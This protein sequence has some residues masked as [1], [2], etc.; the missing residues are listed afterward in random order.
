MTRRVAR[1][2]LAGREAGGEERMLNKWMKHRSASIPKG[3]AL[4][5]TALFFS[6]L[7]VLLFGVV[8]VGVAVNTYL[9]V[10]NA[11]R[12]GG[13]YAVSDPDHSNAQTA[14]VV[15]TAMSNLAYL[16]AT[17]ATIVITR[18]KTHTTG[19]ATTIT[20]YVVYYEPTLGTQPSRFTPD[21]VGA[22]LNSVT[23]KKPG[24]DEFVIVEVFYD[25][26][27]FL[28]AVRTDIPMYSYVIMRVVGH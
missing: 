23:G 9:T 8:Q 15:K 16:D 11:A 28:P 24:D 18:V 3:Q 5:E 13:R 25:Y 6:V 22:R 7:F 2:L 10:I 14:Q 26:P 17:H 21:E 27:F 4:V 20:S 1:L 12:A 19:N